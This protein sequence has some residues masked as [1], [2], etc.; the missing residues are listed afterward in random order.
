MTVG[1]FFPSKGKETIQEAW[2]PEESKNKEREREGEKRKKRER[3]EREESQTV[4]REVQSKVSAQWGTDY[5]LQKLI[6]RTS[7]KFNVLTS[8]SSFPLR[9]K[10]EKPKRKPERLPEKKV[11]KK[12]GQSLAQE[13]NN[14]LWLKLQ[15]VDSQKDQLCVWFQ[16][17]TLTVTW[18]VCMQNHHQ[19]KNYKNCAVWSLI[20]FY[21]LN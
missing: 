16:Y 2:S 3:A 20:P 19:K 6:R 21:I 15:K 12:K 9:S 17:N 4:G 11:E 18:C 7:S 14:L 13:H 8:K 1:A 5:T 10:P